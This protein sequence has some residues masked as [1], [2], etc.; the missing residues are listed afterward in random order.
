MKLL[1]RK[2]DAE[3]IIDNDLTIRG[4]D[5]ATSKA[6]RSRLTFDN[7]QYAQVKNHSPW[8]ST[9][10]NPYLF[11]YSSSDS[12]SLSVPVGFSDTSFSSFPI[13]DTRVYERVP[14]PEFTMSLRG[15][16]EEAAK[17]FISLNEYPLPSGVIIM[18]T[19][20][21]KSILGLYL[22]AHYK[23]KTLIVV[24][25]TDLVTGWLEDIALAFSNKMKV[26]IIKEKKRQV[27]EQITI[28]TLQTLNRLSPEEL[29][30][31]YST[32][33]FVINDE[34]H[35]TPSSTFGLVSNFRARYKLGLSATPE[36]SDG[37]SHIISLYFGKTCYKYTHD[38]KEE[39]ILPV[40]VI[41]RNIPVFF[42]PVCSLYKR[43]DHK[44]YKITSLEAEE[45]LEL[46]SSQ[47]R[48]SEIPYSSRPI[49]QHLVVDSIVIKK[50]ANSIIKD[51]LHE[52]SLGHSCVVFI[53]K[54][55]DCRFYYNLLLPS[56]G[57][58]SIALYYGD[59]KDN[60]SVLKK[61]EEVR[62]FITITTYSK[63]TEGTNVKRWEVAFFVSSMNNEK[64]T[65]QAA[66]R[67]RRTR[68]D[69]INPAL[70]YDYRYPLAYSLSKH[71][72]TREKRYR[73]L[74]FMIQGTPQE[75]GRV[76]TRGYR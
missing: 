23:S 67:I 3:I 25:K 56:V 52:F 20:K 37:L 21:G 70:I 63:A 65:E 7:P 45:H 26:G 32:F 14:F 8:S 29:S 44:Y 1:R 16:Q 74:H 12:S 6:I 13:R 22:A 54:K 39:D 30:V 28:A 9:N 10:V 33:G 34:C 71:G 48:L 18:P 75:R 42:D 38:E 2:N 57:A 64:N 69:K 61:A 17:S 19:G 68:E 55:E 5:E 41:P 4:L 51:I 62:K 43:G 59:T 66:G 73:K 11:Y 36:R 60:D 35:H 58:S 53:S 24:H 27:G 31:L 46:N 49:L 76:F 40:T 50:A 72:S 15:S 47:K